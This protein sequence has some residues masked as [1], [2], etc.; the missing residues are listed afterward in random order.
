MTNNPNTMIADELSIDHPHA[1]GVV[2]PVLESLHQEHRHIPERI[3]SLAINDGQRAGMRTIYRNKLAALVKA[4]NELVAYQAEIR[5]RM[6]DAQMEAASA[7]VADLLR[8]VSRD[9][10][11]SDDE[12]A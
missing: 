12:Q 2:M 1:I 5:A 9:R 11:P 7:A 6:D 3:D 8:P 4:T 10:F